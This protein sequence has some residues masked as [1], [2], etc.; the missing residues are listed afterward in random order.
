MRDLQNANRINP[1][2]YFR[3]DIEKLAANGASKQG[4]AQHFKVSLSVLN[5]WIEENDDFAE[6]FLQGRERE[7]H[8]LHNALYRQATEQG[9]IVA[10]MF[11]LKARHGYKEG[12]QKEQANRV[13]I[14]F[15]LPG[16]MKAEDYQLRKTIDAVMKPAEEGDEPND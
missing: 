4:I 2:A 8:V 12:D 5:R 14:T 3:E 1:P 6:A 11:L 10:A 16:A 13:S 9:N 7:R 15:N